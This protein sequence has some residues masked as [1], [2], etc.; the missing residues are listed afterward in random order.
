M[1][2]TSEASQTCCL[3]QCLGGSEATQ[4]IWRESW[5]GWKFPRL[6]QYLMQCVMQQS[7]GTPSW[8]DERP[9]VLHVQQRY[10][11]MQQKLDGG[12]KM[13]TFHAVIWGEEITKSVRDHVTILLPEMNGSSFRSSVLSVLP[14]PL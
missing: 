11:I 8:L 7:T 4:R 10:K 3:C 6:K 13:L 9:T 14:Y 5:L 12:G 1:S 2:E